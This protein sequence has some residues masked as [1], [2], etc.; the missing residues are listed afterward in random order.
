MHLGGQLHPI[1]EEEQEKSHQQITIDNTPRAFGNNSPIFS[2]NPKA[3][4]TIGFHQKSS[5][6]QPA[7]DM[8]TEEELD[9]SKDQMKQKLIPS[10]HASEA[11]FPDIEK[12]KSSSAEFSIKVNA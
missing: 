10:R 1:N 2:K 11:E 12:V 7:Q 6:E 9:D 3:A 4:R 5:D 8:A